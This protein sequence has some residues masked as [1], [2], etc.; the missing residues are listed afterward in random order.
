MHSVRSASKTQAC[1]VGGA[2]VGVALGR[3]LRWSV[4]QPHLDPA[5]WQVSAEMQAK[6]AGQAPRG[7][8]RL[9]L[10]NSM[11]REVCL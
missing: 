6:L 4:A 1:P 8:A 2:T 3:L 7:P 5:I 11:R 10:R 9:P